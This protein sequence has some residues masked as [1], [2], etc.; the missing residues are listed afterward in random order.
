MPHR[1][2]LVACVCPEP[3]GGD[4]LAGG[5]DHGAESEEVGVEGADGGRNGVVV[6]AGEAAD[7]HLRI[8]RVLQK[9]K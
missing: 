9:E 6:H 4:S 5:D 2:C 3:G 1:G 8:C 7:G